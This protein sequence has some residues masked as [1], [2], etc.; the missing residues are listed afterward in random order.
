MVVCTH[1][2]HPAVIK[3]RFTSVLIVS[4][5]SPLFVWTWKEFTGIQVSVLQHRQM[6][7]IYSCWVHLLAILI[8]YGI[9]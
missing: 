4:A 9:L 2:D 7:N 6:F 1:R 3:R 8:L 5:L